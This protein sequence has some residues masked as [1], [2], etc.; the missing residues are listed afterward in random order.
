MLGGN[1]DEETGTNTGFVMTS[2]STNIE[3]D[4]CFGSQSGVVYAGSEATSGIVDSA[5]SMVFQMLD[6]NKMSPVE[7]LK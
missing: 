5:L 2:S 1:S 4:F 6:A 3:S 7:R